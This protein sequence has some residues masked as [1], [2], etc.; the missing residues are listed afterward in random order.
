[1]CMSVLIQLRAVRVIWWLPCARFGATNKILLRASKVIGPALLVSLVFPWP[2]TY[3]VCLVS[4]NS[5][6]HCD[7]NKACYEL[8]W[9]VWV[10][11]AFIFWYGELWLFVLIWM[12]YIWPH[13]GQ[14][15]NTKYKKAECKLQPRSSKPQCPKING[16]LNE[17]HFIYLFHLM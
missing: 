16:Q 9:L 13:R 4:G 8:S 3:S 14:L 15:Y 12:Q 2:V 7:F 1:M 17:L 5:E 6:A 11:P 10:S